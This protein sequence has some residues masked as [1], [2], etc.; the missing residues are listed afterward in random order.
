M[1]NIIKI[2]LAGPCAFEE[3]EGRGWREQAV[4]MLEQ[5]AEWKGVQIQVINPIDFFTYSEPKHKTHKQVKSFYMHQIKKCDV[6]LCNLNRTKT[7]CGTAQ[8]VQFAVD[9]DVPVIGFG[10]EEIYPW[11]GDVDCEVTFDSLLSAVD[12]CR[13]YYFH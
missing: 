4:K 2:Y 6:V 3:D 7:S 13:D 9:H 5:A 8:E 11:L 12:Y 10:T 1:S